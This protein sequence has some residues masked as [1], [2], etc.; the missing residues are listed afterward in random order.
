MTRS[1]LF[2]TAALTAT[3]LSM[4]AHGAAQEAAHHVSGDIV[5]VAADAGSFRTLLAAAEA[6]GL[7]PTLRSAGPFTVFAPTDAAFAKLPEGTIEALLGDPQR[8]AEVLKYHVVPGRIA[9]RDIL[10]AGS[11]SPAT[12]QGER[13]D[14]RVVDGFVRVDGATVVQAD[15]EATNGIIHV[16]DSVILPGDA[17]ERR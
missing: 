3:T 5:D 7:V 15:V 1:V 13:L 6:A 17:E 14:V 11:A 10:Q 4:P 8:L 2:A 12:A 9:A 16:I